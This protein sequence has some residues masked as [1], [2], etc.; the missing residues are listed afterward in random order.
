[1]DVL[2]FPFHDP[3]NIETN[4]LKK[5]VPVLKANF[6]NAFV[7]ITPKTNDLNQEAVSWLKNDRFFIL[8]FNASASQIGDHYLT[9]TRMRNGKLTF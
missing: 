2:V 8:N 9:A 7:S 3:K 6:Q 4:Y 5:I 1:M